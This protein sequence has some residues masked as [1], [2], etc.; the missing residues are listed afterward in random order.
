[1]K[2]IAIYP[3]LAF[4]LLFIQKL[5]FGFHLSSI[6][7][8]STLF[9]FVLGSVLLIKLKHYIS[10]LIIFF[11]LL[12][13]S[14][15]LILHTFPRTNNENL[16]IYFKSYLRVDTRMN[17]GEGLKK[18]DIVMI[19]SIH[20]KFAKIVSLPKQDATINEKDW[21]GFFSKKQRVQVLGEKEYAVIVGDTQLIIKL[22]ES[23]ILGKVF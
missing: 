2:K 20:G 1:M 18:M 11:V 9:Y 4:I 19:N 13:T 7:L 17:N 15:N 10:G 3:V 22:N 23:Q 14:A 8:F 5:I 12:I 6:H 21:L 16:G